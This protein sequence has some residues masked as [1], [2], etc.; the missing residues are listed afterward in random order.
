M[1]RSLSVF[2]FFALSTVAIIVAQHAP[3][4]TSPFP[5]E[6]LAQATR[7]S[8][9]ALDATPGP[10]G[11]QI[12]DAVVVEIKDAAVSTFETAQEP[13]VAINTDGAVLSAL[14]TIAAGSNADVPAAPRALEAPTVF[15]DQSFDRPTLPAETVGQTPSRTPEHSQLRDM[16]WTALG[17]LQQLGHVT[18]TPGGE[19]S[20]I[21][22]IVRRSL[23]HS[24]N[25]SPAQPAASAPTSAQRPVAVAVHPAPPRAQPEQTFH[26]ANSTRETYTVSPGDNLALIAIKLYGSALKT[27]QLLRDNPA[28][29]AN[30]N[31]LRIGQLIS[32][33]SE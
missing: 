32:Y 19:R 30:P 10:D 4:T 17:S 2:L 18:K 23:A 26:D 21:N 3:R 7:N 29:K 27:D 14:A 15:Q 16:S 24:G 9:D 25:R 13:P 28:L 20:L 22:S 5:S 11:L 12:P 1:L 8:L 31:A 6:P 33:R